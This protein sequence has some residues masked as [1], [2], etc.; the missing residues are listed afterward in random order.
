MARLGPCSS[1]LS[2]AGFGLMRAWRDQK[3]DR[4]AS[5]GPHEKQ[6]TPTLMLLFE[7]S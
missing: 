1:V 4:S 6:V 2:R 5:R 3:K 7:G